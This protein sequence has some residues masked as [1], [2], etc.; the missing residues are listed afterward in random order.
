MKEMCELSCRNIKAPLYGT[1]CMNA[2]FSFCEAALK[3]EPVRKDKRQQSSHLNRFLPRLLRLVFF[4]H[5]LVSC[6]V[7]TVLSQSLLWESLLT[8]IIW[9]Y[10]SLLVAYPSACPAPAAR[11][12]PPSGQCLS[13]WSPSRWA[14]TART[15]PAL[16][17]SPW[18]RSCRWRTSEWMYL[19]EELVKCG[20]SKTNILKFLPPQAKSFMNF[21]LPLVVVSIFVFLNMLLFSSQQKFARD[22]ICNLS[23]NLRNVW[24]GKSHG[25]REKEWAHL[26]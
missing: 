17:S 15:L 21:L 25:G 3:P 24:D 6:I 5:H 11:T 10:F 4:Y 26:W 2:C 13:G 7:I 18:T 22:I 16:A 1:V 12:A 20:G 9:V 19:L 14:S 23:Y 8:I